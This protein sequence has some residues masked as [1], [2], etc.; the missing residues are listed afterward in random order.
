MMTMK[1]L[2]Y[3]EGMCNPLTSEYNYLI[4]RIMVMKPEKCLCVMFLLSFFNLD[5]AQPCD[6]RC[7]LNFCSSNRPIEML[8]LSY[9][10][11]TSD[12]KTKDRH[13]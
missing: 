8:P 1:L 3:D 5:H 4:K 7:M 2:Y 13:G 11:I 12:R 9:S 6:N 10:V